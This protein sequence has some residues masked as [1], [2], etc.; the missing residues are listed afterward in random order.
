MSYYN[1][2]GYRIVQGH[3]FDEEKE[4]FLPHYTIKFRNEDLG[5]SQYKEDG[6]YQYIKSKERAEQ[7]AEIAIEH[8]PEWVEQDDAEVR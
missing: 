6:E 5:V 3:H 4:D 2:D 1:E 8:H 7:I